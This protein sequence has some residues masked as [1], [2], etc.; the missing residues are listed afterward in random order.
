MLRPYL[1]SCVRRSAR[2]HF[3][4]FD[5][6]TDLNFLG[7]LQQALAEV[8][9]MEGLHAPTTN[10][11]AVGATSPRMSAL[12]GKRTLADE[13][14]RMARVAPNKVLNVPKPLR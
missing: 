11:R 12:G 3:D 14:S 2:R 13:P 10:G 8:E 5:H 6:V 4:G 1:H 9:E 7:A